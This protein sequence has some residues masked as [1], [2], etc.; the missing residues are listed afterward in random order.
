MCLNH[1]WQEYDNIII[2][3]N[4]RGAYKLG[5]NSFHKKMR[6]QRIWKFGKKQ[7]HELKNS[8]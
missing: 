6:N 7:T 1:Y 8:Y 3:F 2:D 5:Q 4:K